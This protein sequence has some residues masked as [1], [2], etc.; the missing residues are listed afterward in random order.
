MKNKIL[1]IEP[2]KNN[3]HNGP[4]P[5]SVEPNISTLRCINLLRAKFDVDFIDFKTD[6][7]NE[8]KFVEYI[9]DGD[10]KY[11]FIEIKTYNRYFSLKIIKL[12]KDISKSAIIFCFG[13]HMSEEPSFTLK[14]F[15]ECYII[16]DEIYSFFLNFYKNGYNNIDKIKKSPNLIYKEKNITIRNKYVEITKLDSLPY[17]DLKIMHEKDYYTLY[18]M[19]TFKKRRWGFLNLTKGCRYNCLYCSNTLR[20]SHGE[21]I[22][23]FSIE[24]SIKRIK[25]L[26]KNGFNF[27]RFSDD[28]FLCNKG[29]MIELC[30]KIIKEKIEFKWMAQ[31]RADSLDEESLEIMKI[32]GCECLNIGV[33]TG[34][35]K[36]MKILNKE[37]KVEDIKFCFELCHKYKILTVAF[38]IIGNPEE[39]IKDLDKSYKLLKQ[40]KPDMLQIA[41]FT[42]YPGSKYYSRLTREEKN[43]ANFF[44][45]DNPVSNFSRINGKDLK[46]IMKKW[47]L[48]FY[49]NPRNFCKLFYYRISCLIFNPL[50][51]FRIMTQFIN[52]I[53]K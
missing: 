4:I 50:R 22:Y 1:F 35:N 34:S 26:L 24:E 53:L 31:I 13:Q 30:N 51:E 37:E 41:Y 20:I 23:Q 11:Y 45:Y 21:R 52:Y 12:I 46:N 15:R 3:F 28:C 29:F 2:Y 17:I 6:S 19:K 40:I 8:K 27:I 36:I 9:K 42:P 14:R 38:F 10:Y 48:L 44:H 33:E 5:K 18:P 7:M 16:K 32:A 43:K 47:Y 39:T 49:L 25:R